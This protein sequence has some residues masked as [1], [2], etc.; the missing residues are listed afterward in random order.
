MT[1]QRWRA[2][3]YAKDVLSEVGYCA[4]A[5]VNPGTSLL[6]TDILLTDF[7]IVLHVC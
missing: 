3:T 2:E 5:D 1:G 7:R 6:E 4:D